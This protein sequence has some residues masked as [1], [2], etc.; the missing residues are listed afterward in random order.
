MTTAPARLDSRGPRTPRAVRW[1][2][3]HV[4]LLL[5]AAI[6]GGFAVLA[7][8][9]AVKLVRALGGGVREATVTILGLAAVPAL[10]RGAVVVGEEA[11]YTAA[12]LGVVLGTVHRR[13]ASPRRG[14]G[15]MRHSSNTSPAVLTT[16]S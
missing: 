1:L 15:I 14:A 7:A 9:F 5:G 4:Y 3:Q 2:A 11:A 16:R 13:T 8:V 10:A 6:I 12:V